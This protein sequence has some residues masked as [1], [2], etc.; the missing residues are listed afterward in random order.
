[1]S[2][3]NHHLLRSVMTDSA[4]LFPRQYRCVHSTSVWQ[5][6]KDARIEFR[7][8][9]FAMANT[10]DVDHA[11]ALRKAINDAYE[12]AI[13]A[14]LNEISKYIGPLTPTKETEQ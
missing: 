10:L 11:K 3:Y 2:S 1:M 7:R 6:V 5:T 14:Q 13:D 12:A 8:Y 4:P 9:V